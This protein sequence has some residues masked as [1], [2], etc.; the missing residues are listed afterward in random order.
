MST[1]LLLQI[2]ALIEAEVPNA[3]ALYESFKASGKTL[4]DYVA[5]IKARDAAATAAATA[6]LNR[7]QG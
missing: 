3:I 5:D 4:E 1:T 7:L 2:L 6:E